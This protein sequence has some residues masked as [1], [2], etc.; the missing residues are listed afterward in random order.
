MG[1]CKDCYYYISGAGMKEESGY[2]DY[3]NELGYDGICN[4]T[5]SWTDENDYCSNYK[6]KEE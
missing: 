2:E 3:N 5:D 6:D 4:N 1:L